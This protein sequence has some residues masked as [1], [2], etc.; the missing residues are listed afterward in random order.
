VAGVLGVQND[1]VLDKDLA[2]SV[3]QALGNDER[4]RLE[5]ISVGAQNG[6]ITLNGHVHSAAVRDAAGVI[7]ASVPRVRGVINIIH[8][9]NAVIDPKEYRVWQPLI[10]TQ[11]SATDMQLGQ[12]EKVIIDPQNCRVT[13]FVARGCFPEPGNK[14]GYSLPGLDFRP[15]RRVVVPIEALRYA[16]DSSVLLEIRAAEAAL[17]RSFEPADFVS[18]P[19]GWQP[20]YP[21][22]REQVLF[23]GGRTEVP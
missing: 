10:G 11:V 12:V 23:E 1:L 14:D 22:R 9:P 19:A 8:L 7:A 2:N 15:E 21:Y 3:A 18:P 5:Q 4:T 16:T 13:A 17:Y 6:F 20:P